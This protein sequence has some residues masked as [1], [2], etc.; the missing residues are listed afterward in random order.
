MEKLK[1]LCSDGIEEGELEEINSPLKL[2]KALERRKM[3]AIDD[4][5]FLHQLLTNVNCIQLATT[6]KEFTLRRELELL[7]LNKQ[8]QK[9]NQ[10]SGS[11]GNVGMVGAPC[12]GGHKGVE[13]DSKDGGLVRC[14][15]PVDNEGHGHPSSYQRKPGD[16]DLRVVLKL[17]ATGAWFAGTAFILKR[18]IND[19]KTLILLFNTVVLP[20]GVLVK[21]ICEGSILCVLQANDLQGLHTLWQNYKS[22]TLKKALQEVLITED[23]RNLAKDHEILMDVV[24]DEGMYRDVC[25]E[26]MLN[27]EKVDDVY[28]RVEC[29][30]RSLSDPTIISQLRKPDNTFQEESF[31]IMANSERKRRLDAEKKLD[32]L[33]SGLQLDLRFPELLFTGKNSQDPGDDSSSTTSTWD[34]EE[35]L[36]WEDE[37]D[38]SKEFWSSIKGG[39]KEKSWTDFEDAINREFPDK[40]KQGGPQLLKFLAYVL[41]VNYDRRVSKNISL[42]SFIRMSRWFGPFVKGSQ[43]SCLEKMIDL[44]EHSVSV[45]PDGQKTS[46]FAGYMTEEDAKQKLSSEKGGTFLVRFNTSIV[47]PG[48]VLSKKSRGNDTVAEFTIEVHKNT[49]HVEFGDRIFHSL[50]FLVKELKESW[51]TDLQPFYSPQ[52]IME[53]ES[54]ELQ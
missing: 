52:G 48:F 44:M 53:M 33:I 24:L 35:V 43:D 46:W 25:L 20:S 51:M 15:C 6:V 22:G 49:G 36:D 54:A 7:G 30:P 8:S 26:L 18:Y 34:E 23:L 10:I 14:N 3:I 45:G 9:V 39:L 47:A 29:R 40:L 42:R 32:K 31:R 11:A 16:I 2:F 4:L 19:P 21:W 27:K 38:P 41:R 17:G 28:K 37:N 12:R 5:S 1:F 50:P 13:P